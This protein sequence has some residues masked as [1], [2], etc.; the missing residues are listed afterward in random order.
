MASGLFVFLSHASSAHR[1]SG[2]PTVLCPGR[3]F[4]WLRDEKS[5]TLEAMNE[6]NT[7]ALEGLTD[8]QLEEVVGGDGERDGGGGRAGSG[9][10]GS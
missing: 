3:S 4:G 6:D 10:E 9:T 5:R 1:T 7:E 2:P 8:D